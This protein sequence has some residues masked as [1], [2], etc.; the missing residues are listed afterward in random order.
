L[1]INVLALVYGVA[2]MVLLAIPG[3][4]ALG[5]VDRWIVLIGLAVV[6]VVGGGYM[7]LARPYGSS[8]APEDDAIEV[9]ERLRAQRNSEFGRPMSVD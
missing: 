6:L 5:F 9:S 4:P 2:A 8:E 3:D 1:I 7:M